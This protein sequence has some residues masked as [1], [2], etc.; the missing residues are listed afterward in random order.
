MRSSTR[1]FPRALG[2]QIS[3][4]E[5]QQLPN[6][7]SQSRSPRGYFSLV[8]PSPVAPATF[9]LKRG[10]ATAP[11]AEAPPGLPKVLLQ[12]QPE[13]PSPASEQTTSGRRLTLARW[14]TGE[15]NPL[16]ARVIVNRV[17][18]FHFGEGIVRTSRTSGVMG[19]ARHT[20][21]CLTGLPT[22]S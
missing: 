3:S 19:Y 15:E 13:F 22:G 20:R 5:Q 10:K 1:H 18:Q 9:V 14:I 6:S 12:S 16:T 7:R 2:K 4:C 11:G 17:W 21:N 8:E